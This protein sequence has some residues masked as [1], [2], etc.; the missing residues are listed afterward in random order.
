MFIHNI[1]YE[2]R[3]LEAILLSIIRGLYKNKVVEAYHW[4]PHGS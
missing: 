3:E 1:V 4:I 2:G